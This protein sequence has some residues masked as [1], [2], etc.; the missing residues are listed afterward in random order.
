MAK[1]IATFV[2]P[3]MVLA[4][5]SQAADYSWQTASGDWSAASNWGG[6]LP[7][8]NSL[9]YIV[10]GGTAALTQSGGAYELLLLGSASGS[11]NIQMTTG[12][13]SGQNQIVGDSGTGSFSQSG[14][15]NSVNNDMSI[16]GPVAG[17]FG[18]YTLSGSGLLSVSITL[19]LGDGP[20]TSG[21]FNLSGSGRLSA[22]DEDVGNLGAGTFT[23][24]GGTNSCTFL[25]LSGGLGSAGTYNLN[26]GLLTI[27]S[28]FASGGSAAFNLNGG[29][30]QAG[31]SFSTGLPMTL[32]TSGGGATIDTTSF[33]LTQSG[34]LS[35]PGGLT[36][37]GS[38]TL[39]L[40]GNNTYAGL[41]DV[42]QGQLMV[43]GSLAGLVAVDS[44]GT[45]GGTGS[46]AGATLS[47]GRI[48]RRARS[49]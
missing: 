17:G 41:T 10:N 16:G 27:S 43:N 44:G 13:L 14:G 24:S 5:A 23:Q 42:Q 32:G 48:S 25:G 34:S 47:A 40:K 49:T 29:T 19:T 36:K 22:R 39:V 35:G 26:G 18:L 38:G 9:A 6:T 12:S 2:L 3:G 33:S 30:L 45:L 8:N 46:L 1:R 20:G 21:T 28:L 31:A 7:T 37:V 15:T 11:G 4:T